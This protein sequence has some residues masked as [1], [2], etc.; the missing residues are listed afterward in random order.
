MFKIFRSSK[1][2]IDVR[3]T[4][5]KEIEADDKLDSNSLSKG[6]KSF[7]GRKSSAVLEE[8]LR[9]ADKKILRLRAIANKYYKDKQFL[10]KKLKSRKSY[11]IR[12]TWSFKTLIYIIKIA[13]LPSFIGL[14]LFLNFFLLIYIAF[15]PSFVKP[16]K[17]LES[18]EHFSHGVDY[19]YTIQVESCES[20]AKSQDIVIDLKKIGY[21]AYIGK[22]FQAG[23]K[24][25]RVYVNE[26]ST[27]KEAQ[28]VLKKLKK[29][30][31]YKKSFVRRKY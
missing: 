10:L 4:L 25:Y 1:S 17:S 11:R 27:L 3:A 28:K 7:L 23:T 12:E 24:R 15:Q 13:K 19:P 8:Q 18:E 21:K 5:Y 31:L 9:M 14:M 29:I 30:P 6:D 2:K 20:L 16:S 26:F 22:I